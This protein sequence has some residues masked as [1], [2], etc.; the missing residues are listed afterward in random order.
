MHFFLIIISTARRQQWSGRAD[1]K[2]CF[3]ND[4]KNDL[5]E[6]TKNSINW[7]ETYVF[8]KNNHQLINMFNGLNRFLCLC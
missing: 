6:I 8:Y 5:Y 2:I 1:N 4:E 7:Y 3:K